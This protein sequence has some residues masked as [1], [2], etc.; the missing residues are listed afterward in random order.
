MADNPTAATADSASAPLPTSPEALLAHLEALGIAATVHRHPPVFTVE[1]SQALR[2]SMPGGHIKNLFLRNKK[3]DRMWL[4][5]L[6][7]NAKV[8]LKALAPR[9]DGDKLS[10]GSPDRLMT[11]LGVRPGSVTPLALV[12]DKAGKVEL[13]LDRAILA[14][15]P[16]NCHP[17][18]NDMTVAISA[19]DLERFFAA[20]GHRPRLLDF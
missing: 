10:F 15:D 12:N 6:E 19:A 20:T 7:E 14:M 16:V 11:H 13:V 18:T 3:G 2:G 8:D 4:V 5:V 17:L 9:I 1:E